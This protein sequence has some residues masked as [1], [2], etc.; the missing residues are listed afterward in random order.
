M[1]KIKAKGFSSQ[2]AEV[3]LNDLSYEG[4]IPL[5]LTGSFINNGPAQFEIGDQQF[6]HWFDGFAMLKKFHFHEGAVTFQSRFLRS[7]QYVQSQALQALSRDEFGTYSH[8]S[9]LKTLLYNMIKKNNAVYDNCNVNTV[10]L[11][12]CHAAL[13]E[14]SKI[15]A[16]DA[17]DLNTLGSVN[18]EDKI[19]GEF[20]LA[21][22]H[23]SK[24]TGEIINMSI[25][26]G[27]TCQYHV[28]KFKPG[29]LKREI[30]ATIKSDYFFYM[31]S[32]GITENYIIL[33]KTPYRI[34]QWKIM[35]GMTLA[36]SF[37]WQEG[38]AASFILIDRH[39]K[40]ITEIEAD[41]FSYLHSVNAFEKGNEVIV[42]L[43]TYKK[44]NPYN[45]FYLDNLRSE[46]PKL[47]K[48]NMSRF[49]INSQ[50][51]RCQREILTDNFV[52][53]PRID[54]EAKNGIEYQ[55]V[56][57]ILMEGEDLF[58]NAIQ[59]LNVHTGHIKIWRKSGYYTTESIFVAKK[60]AKLEDE[61]VLLFIA[62]N[63]VTQ[64]SSLFILDAQT[65][66]ET[67]EVFLPFHLPFGLHSNWL[68]QLSLS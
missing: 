21:H 60:E 68:A 29:S 67:A 11:G 23:F 59:K 63:S 17:T 65:M 35:L 52:E 1:L 54:Y 34:N 27:K 49:V 38:A 64:N 39:T 22:P 66:V 15:I 45:Q 8:D 13:T 56:Y 40:E 42:D 19:P 50:K 62:Y 36:E 55:Y 30:I 9:W 20:S 16:F 61:G 12:P 14:S 33:L 46:K 2:L 31:H 26:I 47:L 24:N 41:P 57:S 43:V 10:S 28:Y 18:F 5:W 51:K 58:S 4:K 6:K 53:F 44:G 32:F 48:A 37:Y 7:D 3:T 25:Q